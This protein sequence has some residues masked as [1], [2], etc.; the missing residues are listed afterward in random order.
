M[1]K[2]APVSTSTPGT[3]VIGAAINRVDGFEKVTGAA[4]YSGEYPEAGLVHGVVVSSGIA[5]GRI[6]RID[7]TAAKAMSGVLQVFTHENRPAINGDREYHDH[8]APEGR[9]FRALEDDRIKFSGQPVALVIA[10]TLELAH[11]AAALIEV[12]YEAAPHTT[13]LEVAR[14]REKPPPDSD[15]DAVPEPRGD[16][17]SALANAQVRAEGEYVMPFEH[18][19]PM[20][21]H[22]STVIW[23][24]KGTLGIYDKI[25][26]PRTSHEYVCAVFGLRKEDVHVMS[27][28]VGG[29]FG[30][31]LRPQYQLYLAVMAALA[32]E[33]SV[34]VTLTRQQMFT[35]GYRPHTLQHI[36]LGARRDGGLT[37][38]LHDA[39]ANVSSFE[40]FVENVVT[41]S[42]A[43]Y[44]CDN[45]AYSHR[46][47]PLDL[48]TPQDMRAPGGATGM[49]AIE[50]AMDELAVA[51][52]IDPVQ[53]RLANESSRD[54]NEDKP[55]SSKELPECLRQG[56]EKFGWS[57]RSPQPGSMRDGSDLVGWGMAT[58]IW[59]AFFRKAS[60]SAVLTAD[61]KLDVTSATCDIGTGTYTI[62]TQIAAE[63]LGLPV[64][65]VTFRLGD[66]SFPEAP[67]EG[68]SWTA[69]SVGSAVKLVCEC[70]ARRL[71][72]A[73][74]A[75]PGAPLGQAK[76]EDVR[77]SDG[78]MSLTQNPSVSVSI[79]DAMRSA[80]LERLEQHAN[81]APDSKTRDKYSCYTHSAIF[82]EVKVDADFGTVRVTRVVNAVAGGRILNPKTARS[83]IVGGVVWGIGMALHEE[84]LL[85]HK[86]GRFMNHNLAE[87]HVPANADVP[88]IDVIFVDEHDTIVNPLGVK[89]LG[90]IGIV[91]TAA[92]I[93]NAVFHATSKRVRDLPI[94]LD[95]VMS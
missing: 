6:V 59:E 23:K 24:G 95:K 75:M 65:Q 41:W 55:I 42:G 44:H 4:R 48:Y 78:R 10:E 25:Q 93:A 90:E 94:T 45:T 27:H 30:V 67:I 57:R 15:D 39:V 31:G 88:D 12:E 8:V 73:A 2:R 71:V 61:G 32:L 34:R 43:R 18:H 7:T 46:L 20:E 89:G 56:A 16:A 13:D 83:Q 86:L 54:E 77:F 64:E 11:Y 74:G 38:F 26:G 14:N 36:T 62:M 72:E 60:A 5:V 50:C 1:M 21:M 81:S 84:S 63:T 52:G 79:A 92:A 58:G 29:A 35:L 87:Y 37:A 66:S 40:S 49:Y 51:A 17:R 22:A 80:G 19:N 70:V 85:D 76:L 53:L 33:R 28:Y 82:A 47:V 68:G 9:P 69:A 91:G 3:G